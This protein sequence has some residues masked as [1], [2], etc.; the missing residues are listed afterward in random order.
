MRETKKVRMN[1]ETKKRIDGEFEVESF[2]VGHG[3]F[4]ATYF[5]RKTNTLGMGFDDKD[6]NVAENQAKEELLKNLKLLEEK[7]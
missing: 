7:K 6:R 2:L 4:G 1:R 5:H 3:T